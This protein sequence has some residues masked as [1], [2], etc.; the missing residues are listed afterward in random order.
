[1]KNNT[2]PWTHECIVL[3]PSGNIQ[4]STKYFDNMTVRFL[5]R[6]TTE[7]LTMSAKFIIKIDQWV[8]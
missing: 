1:M 5:N 7:E 8:T 4:G 3:G 2:K 6:L